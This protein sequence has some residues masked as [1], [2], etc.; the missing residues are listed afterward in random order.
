MLFVLDDTA[1]RGNF[2]ATRNQ[3]DLAMASEARLQAERQELSE[4]VF[5]E[6]LLRRKNEPRVSA[7]LL[8]QALQFRDR[9]RALDGQIGILTSRIEQYRQESRLGESGPLQKKQLQFID[10]ELGGVRELY[11]KNLV[12]LTRLTALERER[13]RLDGTVGRKHCR[14]R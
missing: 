13:A 10:Q 12:P 3:F 11:S 5:P 1:P 9:R 7:I 8:D 6:D 4:I 2:D 14:Y